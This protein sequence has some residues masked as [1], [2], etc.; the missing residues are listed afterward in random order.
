MLLKSFKLYKWELGGQEREHVGGGV[1]NSNKKKN[2]NRRKGGHQNTFSNHF[3][4]KSLH[5]VSSPGI[6]PISPSAL[7][8]QPVCS[9]RPS[10]LPFFMKAF[11]SLFKSQARNNLSHFRTV[12]FLWYQKSSYHG[13]ISPKKIFPDHCKWE[14]PSPKLKRKKL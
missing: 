5:G 4:M 9:L 10:P 8:S 14:G 1:I 3:L 7:P 11:L 2:N 6:H 13:L 12:P